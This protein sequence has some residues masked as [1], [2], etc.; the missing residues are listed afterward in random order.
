MEFRSGNS[1]SHPN[2]PDN[3]ADEQTASPET[4]SFA[5]LLSQFEQQHHAP[6]PGG[7]ALQG[8]VVGV[9]ADFVFLDIG[10][11]ME[12]AIPVAE[13][14]DESGH[15]P[16]SRGDV[17]PVTITGANSEGYYTLSKLK[18]ERPRDWSGLEKAF[19][20]QTAIAGVVVGAVKGGLRVDVGARAFM[21]ASRSGAR[22]QAE[23]EKLV[24]QEIRCKII[25]LDV[26]GE[27]VVVDRRAVLQEEEAQ[28]R[29]AR[30]EAFQEG[31]VVTGIVRSLTDFGAFVDIGGVDGLLHVTDM[32]WTRVGKP[33][34]V[35]SP[36]DSI[37]VKILKINRDARKIALGRKQ[38][39]PDPWTL[40]AGK[41]TT[42]CRVRGKVV[43]I[44]EFGAFVELEPGVD[45]LIHI[46][47]LSWSKK[48]R[49]PSEVVQA[50]EMVEVVVL[51]VNAPERR[52]ALGLKQAL[53]DPWEEASRRF[54]VGAVVEGPVSNLAKF[55]AFVDLGDGIEGMIHIGDISREKRLSHPKEALAVGQS[56]RAQV[57]EVD[58][59]TRR[60]RLG[61]KQLEPTTVDVYIAG[62]QAGEVVTGRVVDAR[63]G[64][65][66]VELDEG[67]FATCA[68]AR[69]R[70]ENPA[71][72]AVARKADLSAMTAMLSARWKSGPPQAGGGAG[73]IRS[74]QILSF[75]IVS[76]DAGH[77]RIDL[78]LAS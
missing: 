19:A 24:G 50:G 44:A 2:P 63:P 7:E 71:G 40:A 38:L 3:S 42:G 1:M 5:D 74:G 37:E 13:L 26:A 28:L 58:T 35:V 15:L 52:I 77:K 10:R 9:T 68:V 57:L 53:G 6:A 32:A 73:D 45:G 75:R 11:K 64:S 65:V 61:M 18:V 70:G 41:Y 22:D 4:S 29:Q 51:G 59:A 66:R 46:S 27:D 39:V 8:T 43:R 12:G 55:G 30:F 54:P 69:E 21:P 47:E 17:F 20:G 16:V 23:L 56:V 36:G 62:H 31:Q 49:K 76:L 72:D 25:K 67:V 34:E 78:E 33:S 14:R 60:I 48:I